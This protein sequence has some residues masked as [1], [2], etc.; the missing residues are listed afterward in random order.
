M[1]TI[2]N[3]TVAERQVEVTRQLR[4]ELAA[5][6]AVQTVAAAYAEGL[7]DALL[8]PEAAEDPPL[9]TEDPPTDPDPSE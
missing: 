4:G 5:T 2:S 8:A 7:R 6:V 9:V 1:S 3:N